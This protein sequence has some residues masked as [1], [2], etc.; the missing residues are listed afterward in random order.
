MFRSNTL[1]AVN[2]RIHVARHEL[3]EL[4]KEREAILLE[5]VRGV[6]RTNNKKETENRRLRELL[7][8]NGIDPD[9]D[10]EAEE[11]AQD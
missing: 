4:E 10:E 9:E 5:D 2:Q 11:E 3:M 8:T 6:I 1:A 7:G